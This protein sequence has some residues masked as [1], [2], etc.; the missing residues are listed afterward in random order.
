MPYTQ[1]TQVQSLIIWCPEPH[2][3]IELE[4]SPVLPCMTKQQNNNDNNNKGSLFNET[5]RHQYAYS[6]DRTNKKG[7]YLYTREEIPTMPNLVAFQSIRTPCC[8]STGITL[9]HEWSCDLHTDVQRPDL[10]A[11]RT[12]PLSSELLV[13]CS[14]LAHLT[15]PW[16][17]SFHKNPT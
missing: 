6:F 5:L 12:L 3:C 9:E 10:P 13:S 2:L 14:Q 15:K 4:V 17:K 11:E 7:K 1:P 8:N 16:L